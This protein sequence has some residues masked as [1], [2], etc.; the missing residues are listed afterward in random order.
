M[1]KLRNRF[2]RF[3]FRHRDAGIPN[4][5]LFV[6]LG[7]GLVY[8]LSMFA[9]NYVL[10][11]WLCFDRSLILQGQIWRLITYPLTYG[12][13]NFLLTAISLLCYYSLGRSMED[14]WGTLRFNLYY[15]TGM[16]LMDIFCMIFGGWATATHLNLSLFLGYAT[17]YPDAK[18]LLLFIIPVK[19]W[20]FALF[21]LALV[22]YDI[23]VY[24]SMGL[25]PFSLFPLVALLNYFLFFGKDVIN[26]LPPS[27]RLK[28]Q[29][30]PKAR[31]APPKTIPFRPAEP[32]KPTTVKAGY[33][34]RCTICG[35]TNIS[36][37]DLEFRYCS[38][39]NGYYC[40]CEDHISN[41]TH[42]Q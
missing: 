23:V 38:R 25:F 15:F 34:H 31:K 40:Y 4:L 1:K 29:R 35:R 7:A 42:I 41:H 19:A 30:K 17:M 6:S 32:H 10:Y 3:C 24:T 18:F 36:D 33:D 22:V 27:W 12:T 20:I 13:S 28:L 2:E 37:P 39:C 14:Q 16:I 26:V 21:D 11:D 9:G 5:M 8:L